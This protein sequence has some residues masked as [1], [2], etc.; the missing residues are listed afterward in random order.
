MEQELLKKTQEQV[1]D[2]IQHGFYQE[3]EAICVQAEKVFDNRSLKQLRTVAVIGLKDWT[4]AEILIQKLVKE[5][6][7]AGDYNNLSIVKKN[8]NLLSE[9]KKYAEIAIK[10][11][12]TNPLYFANLSSICWLLGEKSEAFKFIDKALELKNSDTFWQNK[13]A[14]YSDEKNFNESISCYKNAIKINPKSDYYVEIFYI[15]AKQKRYFDAWPFYE[16]RY[17]SM[18]QVRQIVQR[19]DVPVLSFE[20]DKNSKIAIFYEQGL[21]DCL[22]FMRFI[23]DFLA[24]YP[25]AYL[26]D[27]DESV[28]NIT[29]HISIKKELVMQP[30]TEFMLGIMSLPYHLEIT[31][32]PPAYPH[33]KHENSQDTNKKIGIVWAGGPYHPSDDIRSA[34]LRDFE[35]IL[36]QPDW[37]I[38]S[39]MKDKRK[40]KRVGGDEII[41]YAEG[42]EEYKIIDLGNQITDVKSTIELLDQID[43][44]VTVDTAMAHI[45]GLKNVPTYLLISES[46]DWRWGCKENISDW[47]PNMH[48]LRKNNNESY[49]NICNTVVKKIRGE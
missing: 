35:P 39:F 11:N 29:K 33:F 28:K 16:H 15:L 42:F 4:T 25:N 9:A 23:P 20:S 13:A 38:Y 43:I 31:D 32:I 18:P 6:P 26:L 41:D 19:I 7:S 17:I 44:L 21:G 34:Y 10:L 49:R 47:Y 12:F 24:K 14:F 22:M 8:Q 3:A 5:N 46:C 27:T 36:Q 45:A 2:L 37:Q 48:I 40:R 1:I 30:D